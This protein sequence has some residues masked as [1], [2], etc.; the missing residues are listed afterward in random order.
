MPRRCR[1]W[2]PCL[3]P[4]TSRPAFERALDALRDPP[5]VE[6]AGLRDHGLV[7]DAAL[8]HPM[9]VERDVVADRRERWAR[10]AVRPR[11]VDLHTVGG[12]HAEIRR[13]TL[14]LAVRRAVTP[15]EHVRRDVVGWEVVV[16]WMAR[17]ED[18]VAAR[19]VGHD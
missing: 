5:S 2:H 17:L 1:S 3:P 4:A 12:T 10:G 13:A 6:A 19:R 15:G 18:A 7:V 14:P 16:R 11:R 8:V 9:G